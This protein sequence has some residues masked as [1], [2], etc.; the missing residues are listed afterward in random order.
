[1]KAK[2]LILINFIFILNIIFAFHVNV[3]SQNKVNIGFFKDLKEDSVL[4]RINDDFFQ[5]VTSL[6]I[7]ESIKMDKIIGTMLKFKLEKM[8]LKVSTEYGK[9][10]FFNYTAF[11][12]VSIQTLQMVSNNTKVGYAYSVTTT[13]RQLVFLKKHPKT[14]D[15]AATWIRT[16]LNYSNINNFWNHLL[17]TINNEFKDFSIKYYKDN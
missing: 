3:Y 11:F 6:D 1:M 14:G 9:S 8:G 7:D 4:I 13:L 5:N 12:D 17:N 10:K 16:K 2:K 15:Y